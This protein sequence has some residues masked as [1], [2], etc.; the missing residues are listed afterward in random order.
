[1]R[2][3]D[4]KLFFTPMVYNPETQTAEPI[5]DGG[6]VGK[7]LGNYGPYYGTE[8]DSLLPTM[9]DVYDRMPVVTIDPMSIPI[10]SA[11]A[12]IT[13][14]GGIQG[15]DL[16]QENLLTVIPDAGLH[17]EP[18]RDAFNRTV[19]G[20]PYNRIVT[21]SNLQG[22]FADCDNIPLN[23]VLNTQE[24]IKI[25]TCANLNGLVEKITRMVLDLVDLQLSQFRQE[26]DSKFDGSGATADIMPGAQNVPYTPPD[27]G[28]F[29]TITY[30]YRDDIVG[31][32]EHEYRSTPRLLSSQLT[33][34]TIYAIDMYTLSEGDKRYLGTLYKIAEA[35]HAWNK[36]N[37]KLTELSH[38]TNQHFS[39]DVA[40]R[41]F[42]LRTLKPGESAV[43]TP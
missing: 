29:Q 18:Y 3:G 28:Q 19:V 16:R 42:V 39:Y 40:Q 33:P 11:A 22:A 4:F 9:V 41:H 5:A 37:V 26:I 17:V 20:S 7:H 34:G 15:N 21:L 35:P 12:Q 6:A 8:R 31:L 30:V 43:V 27:S 23:T 13:D 38:E 24:P 14:D 10:A 32:G 2:K 1:M 36:P 25:A